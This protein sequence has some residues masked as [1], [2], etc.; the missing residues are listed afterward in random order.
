MKPCSKSTMLGPYYWF[1]TKLPKVQ[2][3]KHYF[4]F[5]VWDS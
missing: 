3:P 5:S 4:I 2:K 1:A